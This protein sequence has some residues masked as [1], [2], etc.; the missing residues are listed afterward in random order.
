M[1]EEEKKVT[2][3]VSEASNTWYRPLR[4]KEQHG[5]AIRHHCK[6]KP[7]HNLTWTRTVSTVKEFSARS[8]A[9]ASYRI[10]PHTRRVSRV[11][12]ATCRGCHIITSPQCLPN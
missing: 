7:K 11:T 1:N 6:M 8:P 12:K 10:Q 2:E 9:T 3:Q 5:S 4:T